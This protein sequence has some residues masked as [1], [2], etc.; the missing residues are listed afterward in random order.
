[1]FTKNLMLAL[2]LATLSGI[3]VSS[4]AVAADDGETKTLL[5]NAYQQTVTVA[6]PDAVSCYAFLP[7]TTAT[8]TAITAVSC[9]F[10][11]TEGT[12]AIVIMGDR[13]NQVQMPL[14]PFFIANTGNLNVGVNATTQLFVNQGDVVY[15]QVYAVGGTNQQQMYCTVSGY[16]S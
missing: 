4:V 10:F 16:H 3:A 2:V 7:A 13:L 12:Q 11:V 6:C 15:I 8:T 14:Q 9:L 1:M 5:K